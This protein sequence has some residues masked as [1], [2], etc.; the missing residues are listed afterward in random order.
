[1]RGVLAQAVCVCAFKKYQPTCEHDLQSTLHCISCLVRSQTVVG[2]HRPPAHHTPRSDCT[3]PLEQRSHF[4]SWSGWHLSLPWELSPIGIIQQ[5]A[6][7][8]CGHGC[9]SRRAFPRILCSC[10]YSVA[11]ERTVTTS[12]L[13]CFVSDN[14]KPVSTFFFKLFFL[15]GLLRLDLQE[16][17]TT[18]AAARRGLLLLGSNLEQRWI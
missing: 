3:P 2:D 14:F 11:S 17:F 10:F 13:S 6:R 16:W 9:F 12:T 1:M 18:G 4:S 8:K 15:G 5:Q 7:S